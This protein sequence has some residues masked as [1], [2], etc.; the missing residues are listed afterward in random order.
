MHASYRLCSIADYAQ[1]ASER[2]IRTASLVDPA[3]L[4][5]PSEEAAPPL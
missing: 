3:S 1:I 4:V 2:P 5:A